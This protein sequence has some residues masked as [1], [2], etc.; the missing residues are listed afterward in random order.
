[1]DD[2]G[3]MRVY[4]V[5]ALFALALAAATG[6]VLRFGLVNGMPPWAANYSAVRHA[7]SHLMYFGWGTLG[8]MALIWAALPGLTGRALPRG[9]HAQMALTALLGLLSFPAFWANGY[10][11]TQ[12]GSAQLPLGA[13][14][15]GLAGLPWFLFVA[16]YLKA[17][18]RL[19]ARPLPL[20]LW[21]WALA[22]LMLAAAGALGVGA[23][24]ALGVENAALFDA[25]LHLFLDLFALG[26]F[27]MATLGLLWAHVGA[28]EAAGWQPTLAL[29]LCLAPSFVLGM[30]PMHASPLVFWTAAL[31]NLLAAG[32]LARHA[33]GLWRRRAALPLL[34]RFALLLLTIQF[35]VAIGAAIPGVWRWAAG[36][37]LRVFV[38]HN[39]L[40]GW[41]SS[42]LLGLLLQGLPTT[43]KRL[44]D[45]LAWVWMAGVSVMLLA[46]LGVGLVQWSPVK[47]GVLLQVAAWSSVLPAAVA[48]AAFV[49]LAAARPRRTAAAPALSGGQPRPTA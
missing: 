25:S 38:L 5:L 1:M 37:Q 42:A 33:W 27:T 20:Q 11:L 47:P 43:Q 15:A 8:I 16:I 3:T 9:V 19:P 28:D 12:V 29:A 14:A 22:L 49:L 6:V 17:T 36:T 48:F 35:A 7:H 40:L 46:L 4:A 30:S 18:W 31:A 45:A 24:T 34:A 21:D 41:M 23:L 39:L 26:W 10:G 44:A 2:R 32:L 13:M